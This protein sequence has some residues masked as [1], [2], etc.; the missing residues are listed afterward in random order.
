MYFLRQRNNVQI[1]FTDTFIVINILAL[2]L[3]TIV[4]IV[5]PTITI[6]NTAIVMVK[7]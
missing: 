3:I 4:N 2:F 7:G 5:N 1:S 6:I